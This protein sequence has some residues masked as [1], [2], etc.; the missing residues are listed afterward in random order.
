MRD[1]KPR[2]SAL[3]PPRPAARP[4]PRCRPRAAPR[5]RRR[6][7]RVGI[8]HRATTVRRRAA[9]SAS[10]AGRRAALVAAGLERDVESAPRAFSPAARSAWISACGSPARSCKPSPTTWPPRDDDAADARIGMGGASPRSAS[11]SA[12]AMSCGRASAATSA[13]SLRSSGRLV[14]IRCS[15]S[16]L[17]A[18]SALGIVLE[19]LDLLAER[20]DVLEAAIDRGEAHV[21]DLVEVAQLV[22]HPLAE[23]AR[24]HLALAG[25]RAACA[26]CARSHGRSSRRSPAACAAHAPCRV[27]SLSSSNGSRLPSRLTMCGIVSSAVSNVV[28]RSSHSLALA[29]APHL[30]PSSASRESMTRVSAALQKGQCM[31][32]AQT[33][34]FA[35]PY[36]GNR[37]H[38]CLDLPAHA[39]DDARSTS[40]PALIAST[41]VGDPAGDLGHL[42][43]AEAARGRRPASPGAG[44]RSRTATS[45]RSARSSC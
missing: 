38:S 12:R 37:A 8:C 11:R 24:R 28:K 5:C 41:H 27:R 16:W 35:A 29:P 14:R 25:A 2:L 4:R 34:R 13:R 23:L 1:T 20:A 19:A 30:A 32:Y 31:A 45:D 39:L 42:L 10:R 43:L 36:T 40:P 21:G 26:R 44:P 3:R 7:P 9:S 22:H 18:S 17:R 33:C 6:Q 15:G